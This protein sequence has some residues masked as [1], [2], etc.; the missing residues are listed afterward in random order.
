MMDI[1]G[2]NNSTLF[3]DEEVPEEWRKE[4]VNMPEFIQGKQ[5]PYST[6]IVRFATKEDLDDFSKLVGQKLT[7]RTKSI[8][9][10]FKS[11]WGNC[12][13]KWEDES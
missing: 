6:L 13:Y 2:A 3:S 9:H 11:H 4:W 5:R 10:P 12:N 1:K 8:W 7:N